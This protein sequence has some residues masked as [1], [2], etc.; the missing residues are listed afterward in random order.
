[1]FISELY[2]KTDDM[3]IDGLTAPL[4]S[5]TWSVLTLPHNLH[6]TKVIDYYRA[7]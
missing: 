4:D 6:D 1:M 7:G 2:N 3:V 5:F